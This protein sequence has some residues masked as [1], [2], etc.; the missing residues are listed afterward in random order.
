MI[1][2]VFRPLS[3]TYPTWAQAKVTDIYNIST[4]AYKKRF[5]EVGDF[6]ITVPITEPTAY[7]I[8]ENMI[9]SVDSK[10]FLIV[11]DIEKTEKQYTFK[12]Y[13]LKY[14]LSLRLSL[15][16]TAEQDD[17]TYGYYVTSGTTEHCIKD[18][19]NYNIVNAHKSRQIYGFSVASDLGRGI[20]SDTYMARLEPL[21]DIIASLCKNAEIGYD[22][23]IDFDY[24]TYLFDVILP[25][26][27]T[28]SQ[29][30]RNCVV[31]CK[32]FLNVSAMTRQTGISEY[33]NA[34]YAINS[35]GST[36][37]DIVTCVTRPDDA[38]TSG[39][40]RRETV[41][42]V[43]CDVATDVETYALKEAEGFVKTDSFEMTATEI[44]GYGELYELGDKVTF[45]D[46][47]LFLNSIIIE[48]S[49]E[50]TGNERK[51]SLA[52]G[53]KKPKIINSIHE[54]VKSNTT[55]ENNTKIDLKKTESGSTTGGVGKTVDVCNEIFNDYANNTVTGRYNH[56]EGEQNNINGYGCHVQGHSNNCSGANANGCFV[57]GV[58]NWLLNY[59]YGSFLFGVSNY[60]NGGQGCDVVG[61][62]N[63][64]GWDSQCTCCSVSGSNNKIDNSLYST[65]NGSHNTMANCSESFITGYGNVLVNELEPCFMFGTRNE[66]VRPTD[67]MPHSYVRY[68]S[69]GGRRFNSEF[70]SET[71]WLMMLGNGNSDPASPVSSNAF[72]VNSSGAVYASGGYNSM[73]ADYAEYFEWTDENAENSDRRGLFVTMDG[74][75]IR[76]ANSD[77][78]YILGVVS[79]NP[80][81]VGDSSEIGWKNQ[82]LTD[83][84]GSPL[85]EIVDYITTDK[86][87]N[88]ISAKE[89]VLT[90]N[91]D[92]DKSKT[93]V[94]RSLRSEWSAVGMVG[95]LIV[96]DDGTC[97]V[98]GYCYPSVNGVATKSANG[99]RVI[100]RLD[101][102][103]IKIIVK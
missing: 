32:N 88:E 60:L 59:P 100:K 74:D 62:S 7:M 13:D 95:K 25:I 58:G 85:T 26:D 33:K 35:G 21:N 57:G 12:G 22:V 71:T 93:F 43:S 27:K 3:G 39:V 23:T 50:R 69:I 52:T 1:I 86:D 4:Y 67:G 40:H 72:G 82:Y 99:Y 56:V 81:V 47:K 63:K 73:G 29:H 78:D 9:F 70:T 53:V 5:W 83:V 34:F 61:Y 36:D 66:W 14:L 79:G 68:L 51:I 65:V 45:K 77:D 75:N 44:N 91:P 90:L 2:S 94:P 103:H 20:K 24:N 16:P 17:G 89:K 18:Y 28:E 54:K 37:T 41:V 97:T 31:F 10:S 49:D 46:D 6:T 76:L 96:C 19:V 98:N 55:A 87:G 42:N 30:D 15:F 102:S 64:M 11:T 84:F 80:S 8:T 38:N 92:Y 101:D 48:V